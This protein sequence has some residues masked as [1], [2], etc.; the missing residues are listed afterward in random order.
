MNPIRFVDDSERLSARLVGHGTVGHGTV[1][2]GTVG[3]GTV[4]PGRCAR[5]AG[6]GESLDAGQALAGLPCGS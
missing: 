1:G 4:V 3:H 6:V 2:H 5:S